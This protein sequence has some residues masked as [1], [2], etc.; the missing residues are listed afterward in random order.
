VKALALDFDGV[1]SDS[2]PECFLVA[3][4][5]YVSMRPDSRFVRELAAFGA[6]LEARDLSGVELSRLQAHPLYADFVEMMPLGNRAED[7]GVELA[8]LE[9]GIAVPDQEAYDEQRNAQ[10]PD[11]LG[12]FHRR[13]YR[14]RDALSSSDFESWHGLLGPYP[15]LLTA[16]R[17]RAG[18][19][20]LAIATAK[21]R[22]SV[23]LLLDAYGIRDLFGVDRVLD[24]ETG[25]NKRAHLEALR[26]GLGIDYPDITF[27]DDKVNHLD[28]VAGLGVR[29]AL[30]AWGYN[31][32]REH[33]LARDRG[34]LVCGL[35]EVDR[36]FD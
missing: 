8:V 23:E 17:R 28:S 2:A 34:Y 36:L 27:V 24:K 5:T 15:D 19:A 3:L 10:A 12:D 4:R 1:I 9:C 20:E 33:A 21:D 30:A 11:F 29:C 18:D 6:P 16:L 26:A 32:P 22:R 31:G 7:F 14:E 25:V 13:F 35:D